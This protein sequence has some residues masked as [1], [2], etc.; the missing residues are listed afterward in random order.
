MIL[1]LKYKWFDMI[2]SGE[3]KE[4]YRDYWKWAHTR[5]LKKFYDRLRKDESDNTIEFRRG[6]T[7][8]AIKVR[9]I[10]IRYHLS[11]I[12]EKDCECRFEWGFDPYKDLIVFRL[13]EIIERKRR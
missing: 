9:C 8:T 1:V 3:K 4:E 11:G 5:Q 13:G 6:Y 2:A 12:V 10:G 7:K